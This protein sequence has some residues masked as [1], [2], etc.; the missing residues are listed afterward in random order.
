MLV[1]TATNGLHY[2]T[3]YVISE[4]V[5]C[6]SGVSPTLWIREC[7]NLSPSLWSAHCTCH[8]WHW[9]CCM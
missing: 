3:K 1:S 7:G 2:E 4:T 9:K 8:P 6:A 5:Q